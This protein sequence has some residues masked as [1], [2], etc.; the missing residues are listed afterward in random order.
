MDFNIKTTKVCIIGLGYVGLPLAIEFG[1]IISV[2]GYDKNKTR[3]N[4]LKLSIDQTHEV[5]KKDFSE[6]YLLQFT[7][8]S[9]DLKNC[10]IFIIT[11]PTPI[12]KDNRPDLSYL[13]SASE[14]VGKYLKPNDIVIYESTVYPGCTEEICVPILEKKSQLKYNKTFFCGY[15]PERINPGDDFHKIKD[16][17]KI[18][19]ASNDNTLKIIDK[20][21][22]LIISAGTHKAKSIRVAEAAK[23][24]E[25]IQR[26][27][28]I[29]FINE[30]SIIFEKLNIDTEEV[31]EAA[32]TKWNF[33]PFKPGLV[34]GHCIGVDPYY[35]THKSQSIGYD[36][37][38]ILA[39]RKLN[40]S[41][42]EH[43]KRILKNK[44]LLDDFN[45]QKSK[46]LILGFTF[47]E[48]CPDIRN[49]GV[50]QIVNSLRKLVFKID[51]FDPLAS[52]NDVKKEYDID[53]EKVPK[54]NYYDV[55]ILAV[56][57]DYFR[58]LGLPKIK[59]F[60]KKK[61]I[62]FDLKYL[63]KKNQTDLRL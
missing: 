10:Q 12:D 29:A 43:V 24:I 40:N 48:N 62:I 60:C 58:S 33:I 1:K 21:Y 37:E 13:I 41:M 3:I 15:S 50:M 59:T 8:K 61:H 23:V 27:I 30:L 22:N 26:D 34:G 57:H 18:T 7:N 4:N 14:T 52:K 47:K 25:N 28:N 9:N 31:L 19:S 39:G 45:L 49:T 11:V 56:E 5:T 38:I 32:S 36:P 46:I 20:L 42:G 63:F 44:M 54:R 16:I 2:V 35:L 17:K 6:S 51:V 55:I 53:L